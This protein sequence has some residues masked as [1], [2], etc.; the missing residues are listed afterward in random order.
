MWG[1]GVVFI[2]MLVVVVVVVVV[3][4]LVLILELYNLHP[5]LNFAKKQNFNPPAK[6]MS[7]LNCSFCCKQQ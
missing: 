3:V 6:F 5:D 2:W 1:L 4:A 7:V